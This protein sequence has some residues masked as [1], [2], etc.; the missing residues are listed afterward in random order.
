[1]ATT[2]A[3]TV[4]R[5]LRELIAANTTVPQTD[6][7]LLEQYAARHDEA[8]FAALVR[9]HGP[10]VWSVCRR[11][12]RDG[13]DAEDAFQATFLV[14]ARAAG[15]VRKQGSLASWLYGVAYRTAAQARRRAA[16]RRRHERR[17]DRRPPA[18]PLDE[19]TGRELL[20]ALDEE[21][22]RLPE[23]LR[24]P[25]VLCHLEGH[26]RDEAARQLR[27]SLSTLQRR[28]ERARGRLRD[29][30]TR[31]GLT[32]SAALA[33]SSLSPGASAAPPPQLTAS[34]VAAARP[35]PGAVSPSAAALANKTLRAVLVTRLLKATALVLTAGLL[36]LGVGA[37][38]NR[39]PAD[40]TAASDPAGQAPAGRPPD[41]PAAPAAE[42][43]ERMTVTGRVSDPDGKQ[44]AGA[45][46]AVLAGVRRLQRYGGLSMD[47]TVLGRGE[48]DGDGTFR[49]TVPRTSSL[50]NWAVDVV[51]ARAGYG[52]GWQSFDPDADRPEVNVRVRLEQVVRG[53]LVDLQGQPAAGVPLGVARLVRVPP[54]EEVAARLEAEKK[55]AEGDGMRM[56]RDVAFDNDY[57][58]LPDTPDGL[59]LW[60]GPVTTD[61]QGRFL[62]RGVGRGM[63]V[64]LDVRDDR[65]AFQQVQI[66]DTSDP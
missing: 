41:P 54:R 28:L 45:Q 62:L 55:R 32:L 42:E 40:K 47:R 17:A 22:Q 60:P 14:L 48:A 61:D 4:L 66:L 9:R 50:R 18:D 57:L 34:A 51:A 21:L 33:A 3:H 49:L 24:A 35:T 6:G 11:L 44:L 26:T 56:S 37:W 52:L 63:A 43:P 39:A 19:I 36:A 7:E 38:A 25:L 31:R 16:A 1:M 13:P 23:P 53:R 5:H 27:L 15:S 64:T 58:A 46:V 30:L 10:L 65:F 8:A 29:R 20:A 59:P 12:L 2:Q